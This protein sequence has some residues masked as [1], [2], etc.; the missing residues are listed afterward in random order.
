MNVDPDSFLRHFDFSIRN[1]VS[2]VNAK[3]RYNCPLHQ[4]SDCSLTAH[5]GVSTVFRCVHPTCG[6]MGDAVSLLSLARRIPI[7]EALDAFRPGGEFNDC[8]R[9]S[10]RTEDFDAYLDAAGV[11][12]ELKA[13]LARCRRAL[14][15]APEKARI[16]PG[17][18]ATTA[19]LLHPC[20][21][22]FLDNDVPKCLQEFTKPKYKGACLILYPYTRDGDVTKIDVVDASNPVFR[23]TVVVTHPSIGVFGEELIRGKTRTV[24]SSER[25]EVVASMYATWTQNRSTQPFFVAFQG[26]PLPESFS[27]VD[28]LAVVSVSDSVTTDEFV[29][30][31]FSAPEIIKGKNPTVKFVNLNKRANDVG[32]NELELITNGNLSGTRPI[33][34]VVAHKF[35]E[36]ARKGQEQE[37]VSMLAREQTPVIARSMVKAYLETKSNNLPGDALLIER[38]SDILS[39]DKAL[40]ST[41]IVLANGRTVHRG[42]TELVGY[43]HH[44]HEVLC[45]VGLSIESK[46]VS[47][48]G[49]TIYVCSV[50]RSDEFPTI[51]VKIPEELTSRPSS[52]Q[53]IVSKAFSERGYNPYIAFYSVPGFS[54]TDVLAKLAE[55]CV[56]RREVNEL[57]L[58]SASEIQ[59]PEVTVRSSGEVLEQSRV[60]TIPDDVLRVYAG[61]PC[62]TELN[63]DPYG[64][65]VS[66]C[67]NLYVA[68]FALG[69]FHVTYQ[70]VYGMFRPD[71]VKSHMMR[72]FFYVETEPGI[73]GRVFK[74]VA[75]LFSGND[76]TPTVNYSDPMRTMQDYSQLGCLPL[77]AYVPTIGNKLSAALDATKTDLL[78]LLDTS[79]AV[80]MNGKVS[81]VYVTP[82]EDT[83]MDRG[84]IGGRDIDALRRSFVPFV[85]KLIKEARI[86]TSFRSSSVPCIAV[87]DECCRIFGVERSPLV[88]NI[89]KNYF[90]GVGMTGFTIFCDLVHRSLVEDARPKIGVVQ[91]PPQKGYSFTRRG[92]HVFVMK[93]CVVV[94]HM[95]A[96]M[97]NQSAKGRYK[98]DIRQ[99]TDEMEATGS[100]VDLPDLG[101]DGSRCWCLSRET[102]ETRIVRPPINLAAELTNGTIGLEPLK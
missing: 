43:G 8:V 18:S 102:W 52:I 59:L 34:E 29:V 26:Y 27:D 10:V 25:P 12:N 4:D 31:M 84:V 2:H 58:D 21:G 65:L 3:K 23:Q 80:M 98:F 46:L 67:D 40:L 83:P 78:G 86:D 76:F 77:I 100:L 72:H 82:S 47:Y 28:A 15:Q 44:G 42:P 39:S 54:W 41:D 35:V 69:V 49:R 93:D 61:I 62:E 88:D 56:V 17:M 68:A 24:L 20:I 6:F 9:G 85:A 36:L 45:N 51:T 66:R 96:D 92:Q 75:D 48:D 99:L 11:Q 74:Q 50:T 1:P 7:K 64:K 16:R 55:H 13:Y 101:I 91:G 97:L 19:K 73:W 33:H 57:G 87:Y 63:A 38:I 70:M 81:A 14:K 89:A 71:I 90:P 53:S 37:I 5:E 95:V 79:T 30:H 60:F 32:I 94:S 22:L